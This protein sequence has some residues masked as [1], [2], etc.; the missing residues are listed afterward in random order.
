MGAEPV[1][2]MEKAYLRL[3]KPDFM[4]NGGF[5]DMSNGKT[6]SNLIDEGVIKGKTCSNFG[7]VVDSNG[8]I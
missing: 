5:F 6:A 7:L 1:E 2:Q 8:I 3:D 4:I